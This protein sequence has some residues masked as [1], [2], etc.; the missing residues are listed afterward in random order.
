MGATYRT[1]AA[2]GGTSGTGNRTAAITPAV[3]DLLVVFCCASGNTN[4]A[5][6]CSDNNGSGTYDR[7]FCVAKNASADRLSCFVRTALMANT[8]S[9]TVTVA[10]GSNT[11]AEI[12]IVAI[13]GMQ[14]VGAAAVKQ[15]ATQ[16]NQTAS[17]TPAPAFSGSCLTDDMTLG[18]VGNG[19]AGGSVETPPTN[20]SERQDVGQSNPTTGLEVVTR[21][22]GF[23]GTTITWGATSATAFASG[24]IELDPSQSL[25][26]AGGISS[27]E[28]FGVMKLLLS[29]VLAGAIA[30]AAAL[31]IGKLNQNL[32]SVGGVTAGE[33]V[34]IPT[35]SLGANF[36][37]VAAINGGN[38]WEHELT[39]AI[40]LPTGISAGDLL[41]VLFASDRYTQISWPS[42]W[43]T[44]FQTNDAWY[45]TTFGVGVR[46][47][48]GTEES[49]IT[50]TT[51]SQDA[52][53]YTTYRITNH[54]G[55]PDF[56]YIA[57]EPSLNP[58]P[59]SLTPFYGTKDTL[60]LAFEDNDGDVSVTAYPVNYTDGRNDRWADF[61]GMGIGSARRQLNAASENPEVFTLSASKAWVAGVL[62]IQPP[63]G[64]Q[65]V[66]YV[67]KI[68]TGEAVG[69]AKVNLNIPG[70]G[71]IASSEAFGTATISLGEAPPQNLAAVGAIGTA[72]VI[73]T[74]KL[75]L[76]LSGAG[77]IASGQAFGTQ[78]INLNLSGAGG[79]ASAQAL[80]TPAL[81][82]EQIIAG[83]GIASGEG[84]GTANLDQNLTVAGAIGTAQALGASKLNLGLNSAGGIASGET[85]GTAKVNQTLTAAG[86][87]D[88]VQFL[89]TAK[90]NQNLTAAGAIATAQGLGTAQV[91]QNASGAG[92]I[93][94]GEG[95]GA[96][97]LN[98][99]VAP[100][101]IAGNES[102][103]TAR[104]NQ[105]IVA[106]GIST[107]EAFGTAGLTQAGGA[108]TLTS[109][110]GI[111]SVESF[112]ASKLNL[113]VS[114]AGIPSS[115]SFGVPAI[116]W[117]L[118]Q[119][120]AA[121]GIA[122]LE[123]FGVPT[124]L[125]PPGLPPPERAFK[126]TGESREAKKAGSARKFKAIRRKRT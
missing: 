17:T 1:S 68:A 63:G 14:K 12:V 98:L 108:Q 106:A 61:A 119:G 99:K 126:A 39:H 88:T 51:S 64:N 3:G 78:K 54:G 9:T 73:G 28:G 47:A 84:L 35:I 71:G 41:L 4:D 87:I 75:N 86:A 49:T 77:G 60:W 118:P 111:S 21:D 90:L 62:A 38:N 69:A 109:A 101:G 18:A 96:A 13:S 122:S 36:P 80:G 95:F 46:I 24:I 103:G 97:K 44:L 31:G 16:A 102:F 58:D 65:R 26:A 57:G 37:V 79:I 82:P 117:A 83:I 107:A 104:V 67:G 113:N 66:I 59:S 40:N 56:A 33:A 100:A 70:V 20:W 112:G 72:E 110:G 120:I 23:T 42:G 74:Q 52:F 94:S 55:I 121:S 6:T 43:S 27:A 8:T 50:V 19:T 124:L 53:A 30:T 85:V 34:G 93:A 32:A 89:G 91:K 76:N 125:L 25:S 2:G 48:D 29:I 11:A 114:L 22:S 81:I 7:I 116:S 92:T 45:G 105:Q 123:V 10:T 115:E 15:S 5:P